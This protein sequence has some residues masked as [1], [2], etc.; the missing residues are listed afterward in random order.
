MFSYLVTTVD[1]ESLLEAKDD[2]TIRRWSEQTPGVTEVRRDQT[3]VYRRVP[4][5]R[6]LQRQ[7]EVELTSPS[8]IHSVTTSDS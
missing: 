2:L 8:G 7:S 6:R 4:D 5:R 3:V 1:G